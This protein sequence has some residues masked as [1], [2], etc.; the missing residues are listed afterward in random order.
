MSTT[1]DG[2]RDAF[3]GALLGTFTG[4]ALGAPVEGWSALRIRREHGEIR[5]MLEGRRGSGRYTDDTQMTIA[6]AESLL[7]S[8]GF[9]GGEFAARLVAA[10]DPTRGYGQ[11]TTDVIRRLRSGEPWQTAADHSYPRG[12]F[13]NGAAIR[14]APVALL[15][16][17][18]RESLGLLAEETALVTHS[19]PLGV[20]GAVL[21]ACQIALAIQSRGEALDPLGFAVVLRS[22]TT[23]TEFRQKL[24]AVEECLEESPTLEAVHNR[25]GCNSTALGSVPTGLY[26]F[27]SHPESFE[28]AVTY[29]VS[30]GGDT[31]SIAAM[32]GAIAGAYH[33]AQAIP[34]RWRRKLEEGPK[35]A[36]YVETLADKLFEKHLELRSARGKRAR[37]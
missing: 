18:D 27:L 8:R 10:Y 32:T 33:G 4:D 2:L 16:H 34:E 25:L 36:S 35:G 31:D 7:E 17:H 28:A 13:G 24:R 22:S 9:D 1:L 3:R 37:K 6:L 21:Q 19:H 26:C 14:M 5:E 23:S 20:A 15:H 29:A 12:S 11:G 30:L